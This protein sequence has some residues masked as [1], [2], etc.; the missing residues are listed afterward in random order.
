[1]QGEDHTAS[2]DSSVSPRESRRSVAEQEAKNRTNRDRRDHRHHRNR[3]DRESRRHRT[4][5]N[6]D[7][8]RESKRRAGHGRGSNKVGATSVSDDNDERRKRREDHDHRSQQRARGN[9]SSSGSSTVVPLAS[10]GRSR[11]DGA[12]ESKLREVHRRSHDSA[13]GELYDGEDGEQ[14]SDDGALFNSIIRQRYPDLG[15]SRSHSHDSADEEL[16]HSK[17]S[18]KDNRQR[19]PD[20]GLG[21]NAV[22]PNP[23]DVASV[24]DDGAI[25]IHATLVDED[26]E[27]K[28]VAAEN[29]RLRKQV[30]DQNQL[31]EELQQSSQDGDQDGDQDAEAEA[32]QKRQRKSCCFVIVVLLLIGVGAGVSAF[33]ATQGG[34]DSRQATVSPGTSPT[35]TPIAPG[36]TTAPSATP[37][38]HEAP[39]DEDCTN[40]ANA[41]PVEGQDESTEE[42]LGFDTTLEMTLE[43]IASADAALP[44]LEEQMQH[45][46]MTKIAGCTAEQLS[47]QR[48]L[49]SKTMERQLQANKYVVLNAQIASMEVL[50]GETCKNSA[51]DCSKVLA[52]MNIYL[53]G[54]EKQFVLIDSLIRLLNGSG[55]ED[56]DLARLLG[57]PNAVTSLTLASIFPND[58]TPAPSPKPTDL[59]SASPSN[60]PTTKTPR[61]TPPPPPATPR[62]QIPG[63]TLEPTDL[64]GVSPSNAPTTKATPSPTPRPTPRPQTPGP[65]MEPTAEE[66]TNFCIGDRA[67]EN[68]D[69]EEY[70]VE[71][72]SCNGDKSCLNAQAWIGEESCTDGACEG[73]SGE[74]GNNSC[75]GRGACQELVDV[76]ISDNACTCKDCCRCILEGDTIPDGSCTALAKEKED[77]EYVPY[78]TFDPVEF[79]CPEGEGGGS[80]SG[81]S[82]GGVGRGGSGSGS[83]NRHE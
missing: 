64:P 55:D 15:R 79:C 12:R 37:P 57:L 77:I 51:A 43:F 19:Y 46:L 65:T 59:P 36:I 20:L 42:V 7:R 27:K 10:Q 83:G 58:P 24:D 73:L 53:Q 23:P 81:G 18:E 60:A 40:I 14:D 54:E 17:D 72:G 30:Q 22:P 3:D 78:Q 16:Y 13:D 75:I 33:L 67:C 35:E 63:P 38:L 2:S 11:A 70:G 8:D 41:D 80:S 25:Q 45:K 68:F 28:S 39:S 34:S 82:G 26:E 21:A 71:C 76:I 69:L 31:R 32:K 50:E 6:H 61:P 62:P 49:R 4:G 66:C 29:E 74:V 1:M 48:G 52:K 9:D 47:G 56:F 5:S 44:I